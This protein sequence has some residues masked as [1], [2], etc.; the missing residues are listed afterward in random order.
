MYHVGD[1]IHKDLGL[2]NQPPSTKLSDKAKIDI[3]VVMLDNKSKKGFAEE[4]VTSAAISKSVINKITF[5]ID[6]PA[7]VFLL[8]W[9]Y[10]YAKKNNYPVVNFTG[11]AGFRPLI[12][13]KL[14]VDLV[15]N[16]DKFGGLVGA[17]VKI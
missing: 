16:A 1:L 7:V 13:L 11:A 6:P 5:D 9:K 15:A 12:G 14:A 3:S 4:N 10:D 2:E 8:K 17:K